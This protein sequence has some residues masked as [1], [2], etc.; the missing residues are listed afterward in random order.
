MS[1]KQI[2]VKEIIT[3]NE[4]VSG[5]SVYLSDAGHWLPEM[6]KARV[7]LDSEHSEL[8]R[9]IEKAQ[10]S[11]RLISLETVRVVHRQGRIEPLRLREKIRATG[12]TTPRQRP[13]QI[14]AGDY[15]SL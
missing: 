14:L 2:T 12:P 3:A 6:Q 1:E 13:Q 9:Q 5:A 15:V 11:T 10:N 4:L 7:F 8:E